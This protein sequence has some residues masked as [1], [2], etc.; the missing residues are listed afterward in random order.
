MIVNQWGF[1]SDKY[2]P[3]WCGA[4]RE[5]PL[6]LCRM[7]GIFTECLSGEMSPCGPWRIIR[8][9]PGR[10]GEGEPCSSWRVPV[11]NVSLVQTALRFEQ[12]HKSIGHRTHEGVW[13]WEGPF[14]AF[15]HFHKDLR[16]C[17][18]RGNGKNM[19]PQWT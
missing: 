11:V 13:E 4:I 3:G 15:A 17:I 12:S 14:Q 2:S 9:E 7:F 10:K 16:S 6:A 5:E 1:V 19:S 8:S 18:R